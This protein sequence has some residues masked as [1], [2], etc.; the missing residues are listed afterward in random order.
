MTSKES[1]VNKDYLTLLK[2]VE[3]EHKKKD[4]YSLNINDRVLVIDFLNT[5]IRAFTANLSFL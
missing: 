2:Q 5:F 3:K 1:I 4:K